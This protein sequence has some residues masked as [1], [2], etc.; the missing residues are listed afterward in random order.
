MK[1]P[2]RQPQ[3]NFVRALLSVL[4]ITGIE[5]QA[6]AKVTE[7]TVFKAGEDGYHTYRIPSIVRAKNGDLLAFAEGRK[8]SA[9]DH[10]DV[11]IVLK[12]SSDGG[13]TWGA[14]QLVQDEWE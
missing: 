13:K 12:H 5:R 8:N 2:K 1:T 9:G 6:D 14:M 4:C 7:V 10:G 3:R 11:D